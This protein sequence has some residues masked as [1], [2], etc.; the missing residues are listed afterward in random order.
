MSDPEADPDYELL[1]PF[2]ACRSNGGAYDDDSFTAGVQF[3]MIFVEAGMLTR[4]TG[5]TKQ[6]H[7]RTQLVP[8]MDLVAMVYG[9]EMTSEPWEHQPNEWTLITMRKP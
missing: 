9:L 3:G 6:W 5:S 4:K 1:I 2:V 7:V 8:Q